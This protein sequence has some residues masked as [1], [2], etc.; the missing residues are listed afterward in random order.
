MGYRVIDVLPIDLD[1]AED[2]LPARIAG[3]RQAPEVKHYLQ[4]V[5]VV[6]LLPQGAADAGRQRLHELIQVIGYLSLHHNLQDS[7]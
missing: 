3:L 2:Y 6:L 5:M 7:R 1:I 4:E